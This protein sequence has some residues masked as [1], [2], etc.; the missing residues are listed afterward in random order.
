[1]KSP[2]AQFR[3]LPLAQGLLPWV[4]V[5]LPLWVALVFSAVFANSAQAGVMT[6]SAPESWSTTPDPSPADD[7]PGPAPTVQQTETPISSSSP[8]SSSQITGA[9]GA[10]I[11]SFPVLLQLPHPTSWLAWVRQKMPGKPSLGNLFRPPRI[12]LQR[13]PC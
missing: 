13:T 7:H 8:S 11:S 2:C 6:S 10:V 4:R 12:E 9:S 5:A 1:M 3:S